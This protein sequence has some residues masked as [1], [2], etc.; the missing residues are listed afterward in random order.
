M[1]KKIKINI[2]GQDIEIPMDMN[3]FNGMFG[4]MGM[5]N[6]NPHR[7]RFS[8][9]LPI[10]MPREIP[11]ETSHHSE[12]SSSQRMENNF[13]K[14]LDNET[15]TNRAIIA[16]HRRL[17]VLED[18]CLPKEMPKQFPMVDSNIMECV[19]KLL[20]DLK[21]AKQKE[22]PSKPKEQKKPT[23]RKPANKPVKSN[24]K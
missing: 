18:K 5:M 9:P 14:L 2:N 6:A 19:V 3:L 4:K 16:L 1:D 21:P 24:K 23:T 20:A 17:K 22:K 11:M 12:Q 7:E 15:R 8:V 13:F 10:S